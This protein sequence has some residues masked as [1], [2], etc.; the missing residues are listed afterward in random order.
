M[1]TWSSYSLSDF[2]LF[3]PQVYQRMF[4]LNNED[5]WPLQPVVLG[6]AALVFMAVARGAPWSG[7]ALLVLLGAAWLA[8]G[9]VFFP[10]RYQAI[11]WLGSSFAAVAGLEGVLLILLAFMGRLRLI[12]RRENRFVSGLGM[13]LLAAGLVAYPLLDLATGSPVRGAQ[14]FAITPDPTAIASLAGLALVDGRMR[15]VAAIIPLLWMSFTALT[16]WTLGLGE[17]LA[18]VAFL[19][20]AVIAVAWPRAVRSTGR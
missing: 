17:V 14:V 19:A 11:N 4:V 9:G 16:L 18:A 6:V 13:V 5:L 8:I 2:L 12:D 3:S 15:F 10:G 20:F 7:R 1:G